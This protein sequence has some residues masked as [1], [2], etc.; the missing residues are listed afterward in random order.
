MKVINYKSK[1]ILCL[2]D[3]FGRHR[4]LVVPQ[5]DIVIHAGDA[6][7]DGNISQLTDF[8]KWFSALEIKYKIFVAGE[9]DL[10]LLLYPDALREMIPGGIDYLE[11]ELIDYNGITFYGLVAQPLMTQKLPIPMYVDILISHGP[12]FGILDNHRG[13]S[14]LSQTI[15]ELE[16]A[17][18]IFG[19]NHSQRGKS[20]K[21]HGRKYINVVSLSK[22]K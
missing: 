1:R 7:R 10:A 22:R 13:C 21:V 5:A 8:F 12:T 18:H 16:P 15:K 6:C 14:V 3:T 2:S 9:H 20:V 17:I 11:N 19:H 4:S